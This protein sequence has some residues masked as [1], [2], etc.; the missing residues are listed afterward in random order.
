MAETGTNTGLFNFQ[1][2]MKQFYDWKPAEDDTAGQALKNTFLADNVQTVLN[3]QMAKDL[4][5]TNAEIADGQMSSAAKLELANT[6]IVRK[7]DHDYGMQKMG[8]EYDFQSKFAVD[9]ANRALNAE[10]QKGDI[11]QNQTKLEGKE[12]RLNIAAQGR[13]ELNQIGAKG[14]E[15][16]RQI[17]TQGNVDVNK[18]G[19]QGSQDRANIQTQGNVDV[20]KI[21]AQ[22]QVDQQNIY[23]QG[24]VDKANIVAQ[25]NVDVNKI[26][27]QGQVDKA[28]IN[29]QGYMDQELQKIKGT[30]ALDQISGQGDQDVRK[31]GATGS[32]ERKNMMQQTK[33]E[34]K[35]AARQ[36]KYA[37]GLAGMF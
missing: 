22:G 23:S 33:E 29:A 30:Q 2:I 36:S 12:N 1:S 18:I 8:A 20:N 31:I 7:D 15:A 11:A 3:N 25:G 6:R 16:N 27:A 26:G 13:E 17:V 5:Y 34:D 21:G 32:E 28:N 10:A 37:R 14:D 24:N 9:E 4:A 19:A 35:T